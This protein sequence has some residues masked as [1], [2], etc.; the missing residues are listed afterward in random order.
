MLSRRVPG[1]A[2]QPLKASIECCRAAGRTSRRPSG[3]FST[4][5]FWPG[6]TLRCRSSSCFSVIWPFAVTV[7]VAISNSYIAMVRGKCLTVNRECKFGAR[8]QL[9][10][11]PCAQLL[12]RQPNPKIELPEQRIHCAH[13]VEAHLVYQFLKDDRIVGEQIHAPLPIVHS[14]RAGDD[15]LHPLGVAPTNHAM[16]VHHALALGKRHGVP[17]H[18]LTA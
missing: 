12:H 2:R 17:V 13:F 18:L 10:L 11:Q 5:T 6:A 7:S 16:L 14:D 9:A 8:L 3:N 15:L 1:L 4:A